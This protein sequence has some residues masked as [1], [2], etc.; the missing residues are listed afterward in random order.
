[1]IPYVTLPNAGHEPRARGRLALGCFWQTSGGTGYHHA[2]FCGLLRLEK[3]PQ[4]L[5]IIPEFSRQCLADFV[6]FFD[7]RVLPH[8]LALKLF[9]GTNNRRD[10]ARLATDLFNATP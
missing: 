5:H 6:D 10:V 3:L 8:G 9:W 4:R 1:M 2:V 7:N